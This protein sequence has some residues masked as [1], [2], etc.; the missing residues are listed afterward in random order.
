EVLGVLQVPK[1]DHV[2]ELGDSLRHSPRVLLFGNV[3][4]DD[5]GRESRVDEI[6]KVT[7]S[8]VVDLPLEERGKLLILHLVVLQRISEVLGER[9]FA[10][11]EEAGH[12]D[13]DG[14]AGIS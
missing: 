4:E 2:E 10:R 1:Q 13:T 6:E 7:D 8:F 5:F 9:A 11:A 3:E 14:L 12:P